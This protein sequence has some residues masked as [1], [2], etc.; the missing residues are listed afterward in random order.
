MADAAL[1]TAAA[2]LPLYVMTAAGQAATDRVACRV[3]EPKPSGPKERAHPPRLRVFARIFN[4]SHFLS[5]TG[6]VAFPSGNP[7]RVQPLA[8]MLKA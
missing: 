7:N 1:V 4:L 6:T 8:I 2:A 5:L 3:R